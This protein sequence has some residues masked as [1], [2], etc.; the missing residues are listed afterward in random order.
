MKRNLSILAALFALFASFAVNPL[1]AQTLVP[2]SATLNSAG[3]VNVGIGPYPAGWT[4]PA[5]L[6]AKVTPPAI[7]SS[8]TWSFTPSMGSMTRNTDGTYTPPTIQFIA[9]VPAGKVAEEGD[10]SPI[11]V[12]APNGSARFTGNG[13]QTILL[14]RPGPN[15]AQS[16][17]GRWSATLSASGLPT[18]NATII[19]NA[20][21]VV[22]I[23]PTTQPIPPNNPP[24]SAILVPGSGFTG[25]TPPPAKIG[26]GSFS[27][28]LAIARWDVVP[29][30]TIGGNL[31]VGVVA[32]H[33]NPVGIDRIEFSANGG[34]WLPVS[35]MS[36][37]PDT[38]VIE[39]VATLQAGLFAADGA[40]ELR[41]I[42]YPA[43]GLP[44]LLDSLMLNVNAHGTLP[45][46][47]RY[48][49][50][51]GSD[52]AGNGLGPGTAFRTVAKAAAA[53]QA[54]AGRADNGI[55]YLEPG[56]YDSS[57]GAVSTSSGW[58]TI[59][60]D[61]SQPNSAAV[62]NAFSGART[63]L[64]RFLNL[65][66]TTQVKQAWQQPNWYDHC[67]LHASSWDDDL[68]FFHAFSP[69]ET[70]T[71]WRRQDYV[72]DCTF[73][74]VRNPARD[75]FFNRNVRIRH[76]GEDAWSDA[77]VV[78]NGTES[79]VNLFS[80]TGYHAD[81]AS[82]SGPGTDNVVWYGIRTVDADGNPAM[83]ESQGL[84]T[85]GNNDVAV[86]NCMIL[87]DHQRPFW[88]DGRAA[89]SIHN[90]LI[91]NSV[92]GDP[93]N[94]PIWDSWSAPESY[95]PPAALTDCVAD[96]SY[97]DLARTIGLSKRFQMST[98]GASFRN[99]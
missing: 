51:T 12:T 9:T 37:N 22:V 89:P 47:I 45:G 93:T 6:S 8:G 61:P 38:G 63:K 46:L 25:P 36:A 52:T 71:D 15:A 85:S 77:T 1:R 40:I 99:E 95:S 35:A 53:I 24:G 58:L 98:A 88:N 26:S 65:T 87:T 19:F 29:N 69:A 74:D 39:Y 80:I 72:T 10:S 67:D 57:P 41:A 34:P 30:Q 96:H 20:A 27:N 21:P 16:P 44:R 75:S 60:G 28:S 55:I 68:R 81:V 2:S 91:L 97:F 31:N 3:T 64:Q 76:I 90:Y 13:T 70:G 17:S 18:L 50:T 56:S 7:P 59:A 79:D 54:V 11:I 32:W 43:V 86:V 42:A 78:I 66:M 4:G 73:H 94:N 23:P 84:S 33:V 49:A 5:T 83:I 62:I 92:L 48:V 82:F 14:G